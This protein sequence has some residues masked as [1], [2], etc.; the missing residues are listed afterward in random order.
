MNSSRRRIGTWGLFLGILAAASARA[1]DLQYRFKSGERVVYEIGVRVELPD[2]ST[3]TSSYLALRPTSVNAEE[4]KFI[5]AAAPFRREDANGVSSSSPSALAPVFRDFVDYAQSKLTVGVRGVAPADDKMLSEEAIL[6]GSKWEIWQAVFPPLPPA[7]KDAW[8]TDRQMHVFHDELRAG[9]NGAGPERMRVEFPVE[10]KDS[11]S[12]VGAHGTMVTV[13]RTYDMSSLQKQGDVPVF[14]LRG[15]G[16]IDFDAGAGRVTAVRWRM[17]EYYNSK[18]L[19]VKV[20]ITVVAKLLSSAE[21]ADLQKQAVQAGAENAARIKEMQEQAR[22]E[23][24]TIHNMLPGMVATVLAG[25]SRGGGEFTTARA[26]RKPVLGFRL[27][28]SNFG[29]QPCFRTIQP[30]YEPPVPGERPQGTV[31]MAKEGYA[32]GAVTAAYGDYPGGLRI[33]FMKIL[34]KGLDVHDTYQSDWYGTQMPNT[35]ELG[36]NG[37]FVY[38]TCGHQGLNCDCLG[39]VIGDA[40]A[41]PADK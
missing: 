36:G 14:Y 10:E 28:T 9:R 20:P 41:A 1:A 21:A 22:G 34:P 23:A 29:G 26:D 30:L 25:T 35:I 7:G 38:G 2:Q 39:L 24:N 5:Y 11:Y 31:V 33:T 37:G 13:N 17:V 15:D 6:G 3:T 16:T 32:V 8:A 40:P 18:N 12:V 19:S 27:E 4:M